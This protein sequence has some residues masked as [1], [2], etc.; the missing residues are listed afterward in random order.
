MEPDPA[1]PPSLLDG[2]RTFVSWMAFLF[3][4]LLVVALV[5]AVVTGQW[6]AAAALVLFAG[7]ACP[8]FAK[9]ARRRQAQEAARQRT[10]EDGQRR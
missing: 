3:F 1:R 2:I 5:V 10:G 6:T 7:I 4:L 9:Q 8:N